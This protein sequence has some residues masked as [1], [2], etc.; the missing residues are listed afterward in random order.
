MTIRLIM[1]IRRIMTVRVFGCAGDVPCGD[2]GLAQANGG[3]VLLGAGAA[4]VPHQQPAPY[5]G[6]VWRGG[7]D[8]RAGRGARNDLRPPLSLWLRIL[9]RF[10]LSSL[11]HVA[12]GDNPCPPKTH[13]GS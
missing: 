5:P 1:A 13:C 7:A 12:D 9:R 6:A 4:D 8:G 11:V 3:A 2:G 10:Q